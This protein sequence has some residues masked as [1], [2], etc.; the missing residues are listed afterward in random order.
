LINILPSSIDAVVHAAQS[1]Y[2]KANAS[3]FTAVNFVAQRLARRFE[4]KRCWVRV[5]PP[6]FGVFFKKL[7]HTLTS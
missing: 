6:D 7:S 4:L 2:I 5:P 1:R 3:F